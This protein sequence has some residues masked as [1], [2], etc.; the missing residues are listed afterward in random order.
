MAFS[1]IFPWLERRFG[2]VVVADLIAR[3]QTVQIDI[4]SEESMIRGLA[5]THLYVSMAKQCRGPIEFFTEEL[6]RIIDEYS[7]DCLI[8]T[9]HNGCK[10]GWA[11]LKIIK[12]ICKS[13]G[14][15]VLFLSTD[16]F[17]KRN[18]PEEE[19]KKQIV[20]FFRSNGLV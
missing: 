13:S 8:F 9:R 6:E 18:S 16:I 5:K 4:S 17:D 10:H 7:G 3:V 15:P 2:A 14:L 12:D 1:N 20:N 11:G 19:I